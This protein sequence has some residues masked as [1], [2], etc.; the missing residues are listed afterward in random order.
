MTEKFRRSERAAPKPI[1]QIPGVKDG[2]ETGSGL[3]FNC[4]RLCDSRIACWGDNRSGE[5]GRSIKE[6]NEEPRIVDG[7]KHAIQ[8]DVGSKHVCVVERSGEMMC[9]GNNQEGQLGNGTLLNTI[10]PTAV[11]MSH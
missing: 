11:R 1:R 6:D 3:N 4:V 5:T 9:W 10:T 8:L 7:V 2:V